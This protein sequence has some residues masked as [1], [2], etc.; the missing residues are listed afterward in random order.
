MQK[1]KM[2]APCGIN[3]GVCIGYLRDKNK[4]LGCN[5]PEE[6]NLHHCSVC[7]IKHCSLKKNYC[8]TCKQFPCQRLKQ[9]DKRYRTRYNTSLINNLMAI[10]E[11]GIKEFIKKDEKKWKCKNCSSVI[12]IHRK[13]CLECGKEYIV[14]KNFEEKE[15]VKL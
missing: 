6:T 10:K 11:I 5:A 1:T 7:I 4:C 2:I 9:L 12:S 14:E 3:C 8:Y 15:K 13:A